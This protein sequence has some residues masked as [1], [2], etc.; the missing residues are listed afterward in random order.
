MKRSILLV[1]GFLVSFITFSQQ[2]IGNGSMETWTGLGTASEEPTNWNSFKT[3]SGTMAW[4]GAQQVW[5]STNIRS[6]ATGSYC[7]QIKCVSIIGVPANGNLTLGQVNMGSSTA[8]SSSNYNISR[9]ADANFSEGITDT[10]DSIVFWVKFTPVNS[11]HEARISVVLH[12]TYDY[13]DGYNVDAGSSTH[14][15]AEAQLD[16]GTTNGSWVR[17]SVPFVYTGPASTNTYIIAT[18][19]TNKTPG[20]GTVNDEVLIDDVELIYNPVNEQIVANDDVAST[21][22]DVA[23]V[24]P[25]LD[26]DTDAE[27]DID[28]NSLVILTQPLYGSVSVNTATG[29]I[30]YTPDPGY[31]GNDSFEYTICD[32]GMPVT[33][34]NAIV[35]VTITEVVTG[36]N[37]IIANDDTA[38]TDQ[39]VPVVIDVDANDVDFENQ[40]DLTSLSVTVD[41]VN[42]SCTVDNLT[43]EITYTPDPGY[44]GMDSFTYS[45]C[46]AGTPSITCD[47]AVVSITVNLAWGID[48]K[49]YAF[50][51]SYNNGIIRIHSDDVQGNFTILNSNG[52]I[53]SN[54]KIQKEINF[55]QAKGIYFIQLQTNQGTFINKIANF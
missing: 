39:D 45:L 13:I 42:G 20:V 26:N 34:D 25:V 50:V 28:G 29:E 46:D 40:I 3:A 30:T 21:F 43:G 17:K 18:F 35:N 37:P 22:E 9:T 12:D 8:T 14:K 52:A 51:V 38:V 47:D 55:E 10:P 54:G 36:N 23:V 4:A 11:S 5:R 1:S 19:A 49:E 31:F 15:V 32:N 7:A 44:F 41:P 53:V 27:N 48:E 6:G 24:V 2:Q 16:Y 33:C